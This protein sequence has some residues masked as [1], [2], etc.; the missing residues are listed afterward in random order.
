MALTIAGLINFK[1][2]VL[3][4]IFINVPKSVFLY[5]AAFAVAAAVVVAAAAV[6]VAVEKQC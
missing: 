4:T 1:A 6:V 5:L 2:L 3:A